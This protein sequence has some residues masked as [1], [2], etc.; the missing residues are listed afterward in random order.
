MKL[1]LRRAPEVIPPG[2]IGTARVDRHTRT[3]LGRLEPGDI[4]VVDHLDMDRATAQQLVDA[5]VSVVVNAVPFISGRYPTQGPTVLVDAGITLVDGV[6]TELFTALK[7][8]RKVRVHEGSVYLDEEVVGKGDVL[9]A[10]R[11]KRELG[12][13]RGGMTTQLE[14]FTHNSTEFLRREEALLLHGRG[15]PRTATRM[16]DRPVAV[17]VGGPELED[18]LRGIERYLK[19]QRPVLIAVDSAAD[20][21]R[22][23]GYRA[24]IV[25]LSSPL[26][27]QATQTKLSAKA[28]KSAKDVVVLVDKGEGKTPTESL[29]RLGVH[30]QRFETSATAED[31]ALLLAAF[32]H[33]SLVVGVGVHATLEDFLDRQRGGLASTFLTRLQVGPRLVDAKALPD[34]YSGRVTPLQIWLVLLFGLLALAAAI[35]VTPVGQEWIDDIGNFLPDLY[36]R[37]K[38]LFT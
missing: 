29:E 13:A 2:V 22:K 12:A 30:P 10:A 3:L 8:G 31:A 11:L 27:S 7:D 24:H 16:A 33:A 23:H 18:E 4:A 9:D 36:D 37:T 14:N 38:G 17:F 5:E 19:E 21:L 28:L 6:G 26:S 1:P 25:V 20:V 15:T 35:A 32:G 34:L